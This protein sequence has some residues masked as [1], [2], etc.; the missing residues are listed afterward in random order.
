MLLLVQV[1]KI[2]KYR[3]LYMCERGWRVVGYNQTLYFTLVLRWDLLVFFSTKNAATAQYVLESITAGLYRLGTTN[4]I[5][6]LKTTVDDRV[7]QQQEQQQNL[8]TIL[9]DRRKLI[10]NT[11]PTK[12]SSLSCHRNAMGGGRIRPHQRDSDDTVEILGA[13]IAVSA[14]HIASAKRPRSDKI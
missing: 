7:N 12:P 10:N 6:I 1:R 5:L 2:E 14:E 4:G 13:N 9:S 8:P 3:R 11:Q